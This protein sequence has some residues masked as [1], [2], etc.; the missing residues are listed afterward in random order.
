MVRVN[1]HFKRIYPEISYEQYVVIAAWIVSKIERLH[2]EECVA[3]DKCVARWFVLAR[4]DIVA[5]KRMDQPSMKTASLPMPI[6]RGSM[7]QEMWQKKKD[8]MH[9]LVCMGVIEKLIFDKI[10]RVICTETSETGSKESFRALELSPLVT[11]S[12]V[13]VGILNNRCNV[14][15]LT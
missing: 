5:K 11:Y 7:P 14:N 12:G 6:G 2:C 4:P 13:L 3:I 8:K 9:E 15:R 1:R 10:L